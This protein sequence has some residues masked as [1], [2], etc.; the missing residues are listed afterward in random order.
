[1]FSTPIFSPNCKDYTENFIYD[2]IKY[3]HA[4]HPNPFFEDTYQE[5]TG[6]K[7]N[8]SEVNFADH[9]WNAKERGLDEELAIS[10]FEKAG[11]YEAIPMPNPM[12]D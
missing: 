8:Y 2:F 3:P 4:D 5:E 12:P 7:F 11:F 10:L 1:M 6:A 9:L